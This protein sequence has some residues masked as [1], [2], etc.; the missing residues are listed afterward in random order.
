MIHPRYLKGRLIG[1]RYHR[2]SV[3]EKGVGRA[4]T[5]RLFPQNKNL[6][7]PYI[8]ASFVFRD[9]DMHRDQIARETERGLA[10]RCYNNF[11]LYSRGTL[12]RRGFYKTC[13]RKFRS[14]VTH[15]AILCFNLLSFHFISLIGI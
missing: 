8:S 13:Y 3:R 14:R 4:K 2:P 10:R 7:R 6:N 12:S 9:G 11:G 1:A 15:S 5:A